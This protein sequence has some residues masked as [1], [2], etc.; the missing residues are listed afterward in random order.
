[1]HENNC[2]NCGAPLPF[3]IHSNEVKCTTCTKINSISENNKK[4]STKN[5]VDNKPQNSKNKS[6]ARKVFD[7]AITS[8]CVVY[9]I[10]FI[11]GK[12]GYDLK[13]YF[14]FSVAFPQKVEI[15]KSDIHNFSL[16]GVNEL[17]RQFQSQIIS[18]RWLDRASS[19]SQLN[20]Q[21]IRD[22]LATN[23]V[24]DDHKDVWVVEFICQTDFKYSSD[25]I[26]ITK[27]IKNRF[28]TFV[29]SNKSIK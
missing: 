7:G 25:S 6:L 18:Q 17:L 2:F 4:K 23:V 29:K 22:C 24:L 19:R 14:H 21:Q 8:I 20:A 11:S 9:F 15:S 1:M 5:R 13:E 12:L 3:A 27:E 28:E 10:F 16:D 26:K